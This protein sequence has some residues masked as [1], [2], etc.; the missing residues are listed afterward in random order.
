MTKGFKLG[1]GA[2]VPRIMS[3]TYCDAQGHSQ[4]VGMMSEEA[5]ALIIDA[6]ASMLHRR[7][8]HWWRDP[9]TNRALVR[10]KGEMIA[11]MHS[12]LSELLEAER[13][14]LADS[15][16]PHLSG[17]SVELADL[18]IRAF[19]YAGGHNIPLGRAFVEKLAY[20]T[21]R[22]DHINKARLAANGKKF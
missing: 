19:D 11:L 16:L 14:S 21:T 1:T 5:Q 22:E 8:A 6:F 9:K 12:E 2:T 3:V 20:N 13:K 4:T 15:H 18:L 7:N 17:A 10:N